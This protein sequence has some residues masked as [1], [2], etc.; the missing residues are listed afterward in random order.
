[1]IEYLEKVAAGRWRTL[2]RFQQYELKVRG[3]VYLDEYDSP[4]FTDAGKAML[5]DRPHHSGIVRGSGQ[6]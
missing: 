2:S 6:G 4:K 5:S 3:L 1:M